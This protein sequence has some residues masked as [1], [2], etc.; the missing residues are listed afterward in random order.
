LDEFQIP[1]AS[2]D[3]AYSSLA[4]HYLANLDR[5]FATVYSG[6][7]PG[8]RFVFSVEHPVFTA[9]SNPGWI[10]GASGNVWPL[11]RYLA[12]GVRSTDWLADGVIKQHRTIATYVNGL[13]RSGFTIARLEEW[14]P[15]AEQVAAHH[16]WVNE[17]ERPPFLL[18]S[19]QR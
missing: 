12:E 5:L 10:P 4:I 16:E 11:D 3:V 18:L 15:T 17:R 8:G 19:A 9:P 1:A 13:I 6:L 7:V 14:G 2:F